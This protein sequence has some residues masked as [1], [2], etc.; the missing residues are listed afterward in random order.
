V[1]LLVEPGRFLVGPAGVLLTCVT[2]LKE[3]GDGQTLAVVD[4]GMND[5]IR[6][7][8]YDAWHPVWPA[9]EPQ[10]G[11]GQAVDVVGP[12]CESADVLARE[13]R[14]GSLRAG[15]IL[16]IGQVGA[17]GFSMSSQY[18]GRPR[19]AE[20]LVDGTRATVVRRR[21]T[22]EDLWGRK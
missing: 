19:P 6:P 18:N 1:Q 11:Q 22:Y 7:A 15:D 5:L 10:V 21:E 2:Y 20:V 8:L 9:A 13:R 3:A 17:Y 14:L 12:V 4:A 16:A